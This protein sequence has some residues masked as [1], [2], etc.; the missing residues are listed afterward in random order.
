VSSAGKQR[1]VAQGGVEGDFG[2]DGRED[3]GFGGARAFLQQQ[4]AGADGRAGFL[5]R[6]SLDVFG[7]PTAKVIGCAQGL[8]D[9]VVGVG[10]HE[11]GELA[12]GPEPVGDGVGDV[13]EILALVEGRVHDDA[14]E[15]AAMA[16]GGVVGCEG[17]EVGAMDAG[18]RH[19]SGRGCGGPQV[20]EVVGVEFDHGHAVGT[21]R[22]AGFDQRA[23]AGGGFED[24]TAADVGADCDDGGQLGR[25]GEE[26]E[27]QLGIFLCGAPHKLTNVE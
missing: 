5:K 22:N 9:L 18:L 20:R 1:Q 14:L 8:T 2:R 13:L 6:A 24:G 4:Q 10:Q 17:E 15:L 12:A 7:G 26:L 16:D 21:F 23:V 25:R 11:G 3:F 19:A 27:G